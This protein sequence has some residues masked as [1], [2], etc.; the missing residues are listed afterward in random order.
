[1]LLHEFMSAHRDEILSACELELRERRAQQTE[2]LDD[3]IARFFDEMIHAIQRDQGVRESYSPLPAG[4]ATAARIGEERQRA[5]ISVNQVPVVFA[6]ISQAVAK[7]GEKYDLTLSAEEYKLLNGCL[8]AGVATSIEKFWSR[9][10][11]SKNQMLTESFGF[12][13]HELRNALGNAHMAFRLLRA[14]G[15]DL[16]GKTAE[17]LARNLSR[18][19]ALVAQGLGT[20]Q[21]QVGVEPV[22]TPVNV[23][24]ALSTL[25]ASAIPE[26][27]VELALE[28][29]EPVWVAADELLLSSAVSNLVHNAVK[30]SPASGTVRV[31]VIAEPDAARIEVEDQCGGLQAEPHEIFKPYVKQREGNSTG[32]GLGLSIAKRAVEA[33]H[34]D[35]SVANRPGHGCTFIARFPLCASP[36]SPS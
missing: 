33:M 2:G 6:A 21:L 35:L 9:E 31:R 27:G 12:I 15:L 13:A 14:G 19:E 28:A 5:G 29:D 8:D 10:T 4:S 36:D 22:L 25:V 24:A 1:M 23:A 7:T 3:Q 11:D 34:G 20:I 26:R 16:H 17:I 32:T 18:M 30:F